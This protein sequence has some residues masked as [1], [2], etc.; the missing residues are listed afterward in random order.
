MSWYLDN[1]NIL[2]YDDLDINLSD[3]F[4]NNQY[5]GTWGIWQSKTENL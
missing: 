1:H 4:F 2:R 3:R 5:V